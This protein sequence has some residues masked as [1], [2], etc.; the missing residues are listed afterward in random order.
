M[1]KSGSSCLVFM[2]RDVNASNYYDEQLS[3]PT[4]ASHSLHRS[5]YQMCLQQQNISACHA[6]DAVAS[7]VHK[8]LQFI[9][10][11]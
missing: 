4:G 7:L 11:K 8:M 5:R 10:T 3:K 2:D 1:L 6:S 9:A